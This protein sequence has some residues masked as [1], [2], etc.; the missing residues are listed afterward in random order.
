MTDQGGVAAKRA[1][2]SPQSRLRTQ[3]LVGQ[4]AISTDCGM[5]YGALS[6]TF[7]P[8]TNITKLL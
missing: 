3:C 4:A 1:S 5:D 6:N 7:L 8:L 2:D